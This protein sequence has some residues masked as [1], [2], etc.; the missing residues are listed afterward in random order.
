MSFAIPSAVSR[1]FSSRH[2]LILFV[3]TACCAALLLCPLGG[4][5][6]NPA[7]LGPLASA[8]PPLF[9]ATAI[10]AGDDNAAMSALHREATL[11]LGQLRGRAVP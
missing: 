10:P 9:G 6:P 2:R 7:A 3:T 1:A 11:A 8:A 5:A 4:R